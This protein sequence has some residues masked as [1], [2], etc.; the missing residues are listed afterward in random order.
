MTDAYDRAPSC[1]NNVSLTEYDCT[2]LSIAFDTPGHKAEENTSQS[3]S[4]DA[5][6]TLVDL[7]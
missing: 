1:N 2:K 7:F 4:L 6:V 3:T 5:L